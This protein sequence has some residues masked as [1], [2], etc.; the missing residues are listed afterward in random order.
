MNSPLGSPVPTSSDP[1][2]IP[3]PLLSPQGSTLASALQGREL[4]PI[5]ELV[6][7]LIPP[8]RFSH[9]LSL[10]TGLSLLPF[11]PKGPT[12]S[13]PQPRSLPQLSMTLSRSSLSLTF[14]K[15]QLLSFFPSLFVTYLSHQL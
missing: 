11:P 3:L 8:S 13:G 12:N 1:D 9:A 15:G 4:L 10:P 2:L 6:L 14:S 5:L 7:V